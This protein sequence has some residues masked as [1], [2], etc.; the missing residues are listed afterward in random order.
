MSTKVTIMLSEDVYPEPPLVMVTLSIT[1][2]CH[3]ASAV[4]PVPAPPRSRTRRQ[5]P[6]PG[7]G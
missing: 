4:A 6:W 7:P 2:D 1:P 3:V 5:P